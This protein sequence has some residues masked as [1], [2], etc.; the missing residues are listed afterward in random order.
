MPKL[1]A[2][3][4]A[5]RMHRIGHRSEVAEIAVVPEG[6]EWI[7][8]IIGA[9]MYRTIFGAHDSPPALGLHRT[10]R[11]QGLRQR[12]AHARTMGYLI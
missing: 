4:R 10:H 11:H 6:R 12:V 5:V 7:R 3:E 1:D 9:L 8:M 2:R